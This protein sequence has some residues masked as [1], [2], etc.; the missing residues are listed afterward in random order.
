MTNTLTEQAAVNWLSTIAAT[1][2][3]DQAIVELGVY[4]GG[5]L[6]HLCDGAQQGNNPPVFGI[7]GWGITSIYRNKPQMRRRYGQQNQRIAAQAAPTATL[8]RDLSTNTGHH[9]DGPPVG[10]LYV[11]ATHGYHAV[12]A[13]YQAWQPHLAPHA[14]VAFD[15]YRSDRFPGVV[16][17]VD[18]LVQ[19]GH[20]EPITIIGTRLATTRTPQ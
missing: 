8:I 15:D 16:K 6:T 10:L 2:P 14:V 17:A 18:Q 20:L 4:Q 19:D 9:W 13:D 11:D 3:K 12:I 1:I 5:S 7:D